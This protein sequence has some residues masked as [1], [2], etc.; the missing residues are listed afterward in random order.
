MITSKSHLAR[1]GFFFCESK[2][3]KTCAENSHT[4]DAKDDKTKRGENSLF[5]MECLSFLV[6]FFFF[7]WY[8]Y[9]VQ[10]KV[11]H[12]YTQLNSWQ[13]SWVKYFHVI[14]THIS[15]CQHIH[16]RFLEEKGDKNTDINFRFFSSVAEEI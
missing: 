15:M 7:C 8:C 11:N 13:V 9:L 14:V 3:G 4:G 12:L 6:F 10:S 2:K 16:S 1:Q 5:T